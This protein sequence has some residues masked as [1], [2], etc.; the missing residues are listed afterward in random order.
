MVRLGNDPASR[1]PNPLEGRNM[2]ISSVQVV[3]VGLVA[4]TSGCGV[5]VQKADQVAGADFRQALAQSHPA[6]KLDDSGCVELVLK[7]IPNATEDELALLNLVAIYANADEADDASSV[8]EYGLVGAKDDV[9]GKIR[10]WT[11][12]TEAD[13]DVIVKFTGDDWRRVQR[14]ARRGRAGWARR[15]VIKQ[16]RRYHSDPES[17]FA[18]QPRWLARVLPFQRR[19]ELEVLGHV[20]FREDDKEMR[21]SEWFAARRIWDILD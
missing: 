5:E 8:I 20:W 2:R 13:L 19:I 12:D 17:Y 3:V 18:S 10:S 14:D 21:F 7:A 4:F 11:E 1:G 15:R 9:P 16:L 6:F